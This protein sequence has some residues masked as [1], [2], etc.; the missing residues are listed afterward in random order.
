MV[1]DFFS[2]YEVSATLVHDLIRDNRLAI[3]SITAFELYAGVTGKRRIQQIDKLVSSVPVIPF[4]LTEAAIAARIYNS[5][6]RS[7]ILIGNQDICIAA[8]CM[9][10]DLQLMTRNIEHFSR[11]RNLRLYNGLA[12]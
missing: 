3:S 2:G 5:L 1:I 12:P 7:G 6:R 11:V 8:T 9:S 10:R 4:T